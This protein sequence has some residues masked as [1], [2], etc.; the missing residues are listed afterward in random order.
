MDSE[1][2]KLQLMTTDGCH[3]CEQALTLFDRSRLKQGFSLELV[4]IMDDNTLLELYQTSIPVFV[5]P[6]S[7]ASLGW[8]FSIV[9]LDTFLSRIQS[10]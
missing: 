2:R 1:K 9:E 5:A 10:Q 3:L 6:A 4:D 7:N 8:P